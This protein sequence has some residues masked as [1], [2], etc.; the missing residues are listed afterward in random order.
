MAFYC[1]KV[2][3]KRYVQTIKPQI[4]PQAASIFYNKSQ[5]T[6][7]FLHATVDQTHPVGQKKTFVSHKH[8][9]YHIVLYTSGYGEYSIEGRFHPAQ[10]GTCVLIGPGQYHDFVS[11]WKQSVYSEITFAYESMRQ[12]LRLPFDQ[13]LSLHTGYDISLE[14]HVTLSMDQ[15]YNLQSLLAK[16]ITHLNS[17]QIYSQ[18]L[19][20]YDLA[21]IFNFLVEIAVSSD[22]TPFSQSRFERAKSYIEEHYFDQITMDEL[23]K[24]AAVSKGYFFR[25]FKK[26]FGA[27]PLAYQQ[28]IRIE[29]AKT[30]LKT[31]TLRC[32]EIAYRIGFNDVYFFHRIFKK[33][34]GQTPNEYRKQQTLK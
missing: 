1:T 10:P 22:Q 13:L 20:H 19:A 4:P 18:Y 32:N 29:A 14:S 25:E 16:S 27:P 9:F 23:A 30:L 5:Y 17:T 7:S 34:I 11:R 6:P 31:T 26:Q 15:M 2:T 21:T 24:I 28:S 33:R 3:M 8:D 12:S